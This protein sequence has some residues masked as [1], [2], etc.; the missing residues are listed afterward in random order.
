MRRFR[1]IP[2]LEGRSAA[3][4]VALAVCGAAVLGL[5]RGVA[6]VVENQYLSLDMPRLI[7]VTLHDSLRQ[8]LLFVGLPIAAGVL[9]LAAPRSAR[10]EGS[11]QRLTGPLR[12][13]ARGI[14]IAAALLLL[15]VFTF[16]AAIEIELREPRPQKPNVVWIVVDAL[17]ADHLGAYGYSRPTSPF[18]DDW[19]RRATLFR[20]AYTQESYTIASV[21]SFFT[22]TYPW[23]HRVLYDAPSIDALDSSFV[24]LAEILREQDYRTA[25]FVFNPHLKARFNFDQGFDVY[26]DRQEMFRRFQPD[27]ERFETAQRIH[28]KTQRLLR[29]HDGSPL[30]L[31]LHFRDVHSPYV[32]LAPYDEMFPPRDASERE[33]RISLYDGEI[34][35]TDDWLARLFTLLA[36]NGIDASN[37][38]FVYTADHGEEFQD[39]HPGDSGGWYHGRTLYEELLHVPLVLSVPGGRFAGR[40]V[41]EPVGLIDLAPTILD[42]LDIDWARFRGQFRGRSLV[43]PMEG[44]AADASAVVRA[45][46]NHGRLALIGPRWKYYRSHP[47]TK[48]GDP[49]ALIRPSGPETRDFGEELYDLSADPRES[50]DLKDR[51]PEVLAQFRKDA[52]AMPRSGWE[53]PLRHE[54][55]DPKTARELRALGYLE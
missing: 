43:G 10:R 9:I 4:L 7:A 47:P 27:P 3:V 6:E 40:V 29:E 54:P 15:V 5:A 49:P 17:R 23:E 31:Y 2:R 11:P 8:A 13:H 51:H 14:G 34:R 50:V 55:I 12:R 32:P 28:A 20:R 33:K 42:L 22:S 39:P 37:T 53:D 26:D 46:G 35:Y 16:G 25:A 45:G 44:R 19:S 24:T 38:L 48:R 21:A 41:E 36:E 1:S 18:L 30:F 52:D